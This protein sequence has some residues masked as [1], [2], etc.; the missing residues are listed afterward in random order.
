MLGFASAGYGVFAAVMGAVFVWY[1]FGVYRMKD[2]DERMI[3]A[4]KL[5]GF[6]ILYLFALFAAIL[7][8]VIVGDMLRL[9]SVGLA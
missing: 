5:F 7:V 3:P 9:F 1:A 8:D 6:S 2:G 4:K